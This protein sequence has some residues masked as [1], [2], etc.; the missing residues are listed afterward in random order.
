MKIFI[1]I[2][3]IFT[4]C[5]SAMADWTKIGNT[6]DAVFYIDKSTIVKQG[7]VSTMK[8]MF[9]YKKEVVKNGSAPYLSSIGVN[10]Y[11]CVDKLTMIVTVSNFSNK[12]GTGE[13]TNTLTPIPHWTAIPANSLNE[14]I[15][16]NLCHKN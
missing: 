7:N 13:I 4:V 16:E 3:A 10:Q 14:G 15:W 2:I 5:N 11:D 8:M 9:D 6:K 1:F 12:M